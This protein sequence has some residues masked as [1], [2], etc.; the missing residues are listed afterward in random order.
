MSKILKYLPELKD[1]EQVYIAQVLTPMDDEKAQQFAHLY[2]SRRR[3]PMIVLLL[4][5]L[6]FVGLGGIN[7]FYLDQI[8]MG[9]LFILTVGVCFVGSIIDAFNYKELTFEYN[10]RQADELVALM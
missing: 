2:R 3:D 8:G 10:R 7:R 1:E 4:T 5:L 9:I 6:V